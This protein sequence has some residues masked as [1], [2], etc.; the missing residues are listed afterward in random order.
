VRQRERKPL[1]ARRVWR[2]VRRGLLVF[3]LLLL[4][5]LLVLTRT[6]VTK[7][8]VLPRLESALNLDISAGSV[9]IASD[10]SVVVRDARFRVP[11]LRGE[12]GEILRFDRLVARIDWLRLPSPSAVVEVEL[13]QPRLRLSQHKETGEINAASLAFFGRVRGGE[14]AALPT[15]VVR[16]GAVELGEHDGAAY[17]SLASVPLSGVLAPPKAGGS[18]PSLFS[19]TR[20]I[21]ESGIEVTGLVGPGGVTFTLGGLTLNDWPDE[22]IPTRWRPLWAALDLDGRVVPR[23][24]TISPE[25]D[26]EIEVAV[27]RVAL[28]IPFAEDAARDGEPIRLADVNGSFI[29]TDRMLSADL[30][31]RVG[32]LTERVVFDLWGFDAN[33]SPF[34]ARLTTEP[35]RL[36]RDLGLL[37][38][39][40]AAVLEQLERFNRPEGDVE[41]TIWLA[42]GSRPEGQPAPMTGS[43]ELPPGL[44]LV[45]DRGQIRLDGTLRMWN[46]T[47]AYQGFPYPFTD[48]GGVFRFTR[49]RLEFGELRGTGPTGA[50]LGGSGVIGPLGPNA[51]VDLDLRVD[52]LPIDEALIAVLSPSRRA[53]VRGLFSEAK[54]ADLVA[55]GLLRSNE[56][57]AA[58]HARLGAI[59]AEREAW[60]TG[61][62]APGEL[63]RLDEE[64]RRIEAA[65][66]DKP[67][68]RL[69]GVADATIRVLRHEGEQSVW[70]RDIRLSMDEVGL[71]SEYFALPTIGRR[72]EFSINE[73]TTAF[74]VAEGSTLRGGEV[75]INARVQLGDDDAQSIPEIDITA[76]D[77]PIDDLLL[78][79]I[80][81]PGEEGEAGG[82]GML[83]RVLHRLNLSGTLDSTAAIGPEN[84]E[85]GYQIQTLVSGVNA[86]VAGAGVDLEGLVGTVSV[87]RDRVGLDLTGAVAVPGSSERIDGARLTA[88]IALPPGASWT[89]LD[90]TGATPSID[91][92]VALPEADLRVPAERLIAVFDEQTAARVAELRERYRP[93]G[94][95]DIETRLVG[96]LGAGAVGTPDITVRAG[97]VRR[98]AFDAGEIR[99]EATSGQGEAV[100][101]LGEDRRADFRDFS[102]E[103]GAGGVPGGRLRINDT[104]PLRDLKGAAWEA[105]LDGGRFE[106]PLT[107][108]AIERAARGG[109]ADLFAQREPRGVFDLV[110]RHRPD[111]EF[112]GTLSPRSLTLATPRGDAR[113]DSAGGSIEFG[114]GGGAISALRLDAPDASIGLRGGWTIEGE[115]ARLDLEIDGR[116][117]R[118]TPPLLGLAPDAVGS[119][120]DAIGVHADG[121]IELRALRVETEG[122]MTGRAEGPGVPVRVT[123]TALVTDAGLRVGIPVTELTGLIS[124]KVVTGPGSAEPAF[125]VTVEAD[126]WR[127]LGL[128]MTDGRAEALSGRDPGS[129]LVPVL[130][131]DTHGGRFTGAVRVSPESRGERRY[132]ADLQLAEV[133]LAPLLEDVSLAE[134]GTLADA[135][136]DDLERAYPEEDWNKSQDR[137]RGL[138]N[139]S[140]SL[141]GSSAGDAGR[142]GRGRVIVSGGPVVQLPLLTPLIEFSNLRLPVGDELRLGFAS[143]YLDESGVTFED[144]AVISESVELLGFGAMTWP[145]TD[146]DLRIRSQARERIPVLSTMVEAV[147]DELL[148]TRVQGP[149]ADP[150][151]STESFSA[152]RRVMGSLF[153]GGVSPNYLR[154]REISANAGATRDRIR[155][156]AELLDRIGTGQVSPSAQGGNDLP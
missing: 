72:V 75:S 102:V 38:Y 30:S 23:R 57:A 153:G 78:H 109:L 77:V 2:K 52:D 55:E 69:A 95:L 135:V 33:R 68:F 35:F 115:R 99:V 86:R 53:L 149:L 45:G 137:S 111:D 127:L 47:A 84:G 107:K 74:R 140:F 46:A 138:V 62:M 14:V 22:A 44:A 128:R 142:R 7:S 131:A 5:G 18:G 110:L 34:L 20:A 65:L 91:A 145:G 100:L 85:I 97:G 28:N 11:G 29:I 49:D 120:F 40:P 112:E 25:G 82:A 32:T 70:E 63:G 27:D 80:A 43:L 9:V 37:D 126:R 155:Q 26:A 125:S 101:H 105:R 48:M 50:R 39:V 113:F 151:I 134:G 79:V 12:A 16:N 123:G 59:E 130:H 121:P 56:E 87:S 147:R 6:G 71:L 156:A 31:G 122:P 106:S 132:W 19:L 141:T 90:E 83:A 66:R 67:A 103:L 15:V 139:A 144:L 88:A 96:T 152:T 124:F 10:L 89:E 17:E 116:A 129:I 148:T 54:H 4:V 94:R 119:L 104:I 92:S 3:I 60:T 8:L 136:R 118:L 143:L 154:L 36:E 76:T 64:R 114:P 98:L 13:E 51:A 1:T 117:E 133:R 81:G 108:A 73:E 146:L 58:M 150:R 41:A 61:G 24:V 42:R 93:E 21:G